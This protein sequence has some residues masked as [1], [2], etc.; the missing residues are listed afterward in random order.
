MVFTLDTIP[1]LLMAYGYALLFP[2]AIIEGPIISIIAGLLVAGGFLNLYIT[3]GV[4]IFGD[5]VGDTL[6]YSIGRYGGNYFV[7]RWGWLLNID[8]SKLLRLEENFN[9]HSAKWLFFAKAQGLGSAI[10]VAAGVIKMPFGRFLWLNF[11]A[12]I[13]KSAI[14]LAIG[15]YFGKAYVSINGYINKFGIITIFLIIVGGILYFLRR[16]KY[17]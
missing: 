5:L 9:T 3:Y 8:G 12:T 16:K 1:Q 17:I 2:I 4:L 6:Y 11:L 15:F 7:K 10:L 13:C 14:F